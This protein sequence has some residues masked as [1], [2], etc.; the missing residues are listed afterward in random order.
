MVEG[1]KLGE[2][3][4]HRSVAPLLIGLEDA[5]TDAAGWAAVV[6][7]RLRINVDPF[8]AR[9]VLSWT[10]PRRSRTQPAS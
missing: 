5:A 9:L 2:E 4:L 6:R 3:C 10:D 8:F 7:G 1:T